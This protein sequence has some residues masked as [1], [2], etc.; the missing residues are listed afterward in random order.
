MARMFRSLQS[1]EK[2]DPDPTSDAAHR[3]TVEAG[4]LAALM[5][6]TDLETVTANAARRFRCVSWD[7][8][9]AE[10]VNLGGLISRYR[11]TLE[12]SFSAASKPI[13]AIKYS[14]HFST[15]FEI[16]KI[17]IP[18]HLRSRSGKNRAPT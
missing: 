12:G 9:R 17:Y 11:Q 16:Y 8:L 5:E 18:L 7:V 2:T 13:F 14:T 4:T 3:R 10:L 1:K 6:G 15:L